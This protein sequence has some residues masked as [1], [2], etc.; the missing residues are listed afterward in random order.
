MKRENVYPFTAIVGQESMKTA[1]LMSIV[2]PLLGGVLIQGEKGTAK[3]TAVRALAALLP[4]RQ[5]VEGCRFRC[6]PDHP[7]E[8][9]GGMQ[10]TFRRRNCSVGQCAHEGGGASGE[11][12]GG[13]RGGDAGY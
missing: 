6:S 2:S 7:S 4:P 1:L 13:P 10:G 8:W 12:Y 5:C 9:C 3:S 11:R